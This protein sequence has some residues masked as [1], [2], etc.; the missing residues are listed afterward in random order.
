MLD[1]YLKNLTRPPERSVALAVVAIVAALLSFGWALLNQQWLYLRMAQVLVG[2]S[3]LSV[4]I[5][6]LL[7]RTA[8]R[9][10]IF[11]RIFGLICAGA[12]LLALVLNLVTG[13]FRTLTIGS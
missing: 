9:P 2:L 13:E 8:L 12:G 1:R 4:G 5:N 6:A 10:A 3:M 11:L 7:P